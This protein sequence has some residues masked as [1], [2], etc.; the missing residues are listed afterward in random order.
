MCPLEKL[1]SVS[2]K[3][4]FQHF[5]LSLSSNTLLF[6][7]GPSC[8]F[9]CLKSSEAFW[10]N[11]LHHPF[12]SQEISLDLLAYSFHLFLWSC[13]RNDFPLT[14]ISSIASFSLSQYTE[15]LPFISIPLHISTLLF[16]IRFLQ[17]KGGG[18]CGSCLLLHPLVLIIWFYARLSTVMVAF[19]GH[20][21]S[22]SVAFSCCFCS[23]NSLWYL[24]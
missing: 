4:Y 2:H 15:F 10:F 11:I 13:L 5:P 8:L 14:P 22:G 7:S 23:M 24:H 18:S 20:R 17:G 19:E 1:F 6:L 9:S 12:S 3:G 16:T 21:W